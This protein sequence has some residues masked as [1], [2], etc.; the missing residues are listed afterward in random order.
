[1]ELSRNIFMVNLHDFKSSINN[2]FPYGQ[3]CYDVSNFL[4]AH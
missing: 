4:Q 3:L 1:M 2:K